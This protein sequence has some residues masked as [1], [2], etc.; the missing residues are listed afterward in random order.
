MWFMMGS[1][2][3]SSDPNLAGLLSA[4][5]DGDQE[6]FAELY[7]L[8]SARVHGL[9]V[10]VLRDV[11]Q[12]EEVTQEVYLQVWRSAGRFD[13]HRGSALS[14]LLTLGHRRAIDRVRSAQSQSDRD[15]AYESRAD[16]PTP[17]PTAEAVEDRLQGQGVRSAVKELGPPHQE[18]LEL[19]YFEG[20]TH[21]E[22]SERLGVPLGTA[23]TRIRDGLRKLRD[24][25]GGAR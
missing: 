6:A 18:A 1:M 11:A 2:P 14:W 10:R 25:T 20:L 7:D 16:R 23:K 13:A 24:Q 9:V 22:V 15:Q 4:T 12:A 21:Q 17:D 5:A 8:T 19:A 3:A